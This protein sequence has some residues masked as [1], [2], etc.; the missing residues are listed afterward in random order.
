[1]IGRKREIHELNR[2]YDSSKAEFAAIYGRRRVGKTFLVDSVFGGRYAFRHAGLSP[3]EGEKVTT[4]RDQL[5]HFY[6]SLL[7]YGM[8][9]CEKPKSWLD[10][11]FL[12]EKLL[13][14]KDNGGKQVI[15]I[16]ELPWLDTPRSGFVTALEAFWNSFAC[17]R[18]N[19][20]LIVCGSA[21][22]W[23]RDKLINNHGGLYGRLTCEL[24]LSPFSLA[25]CKAF[26][27]QN[28][29]DY[30]E[31]DVT[32]SYMIIGGIPYYMG[33][34]RAG[35][36]LA[37]NIDEMFFAKNAVLGNEY[38]RLFASVFG[39]PMASKKIVEVL[40]KRN[41]GYTRDEIATAIGM[42]DGGGLSDIINALISSDFVIKYTPFGMSRRNVYYKLVDPFCLFCVHFMCGEYR[43]EHFWQERV[44]S[45]EISSW[46]GRAFEN[47]C[48]NHIS[49]IKNALGISGV[50][51]EESAWTRIKDDTD[52]MQI[53]MIITRRDN[54]VNVCEMKFYSDEFA[55]D[56]DYYK[57][58]L[59]RQEAVRGMVHKKMSVQNTLITTYGLVKN[60]YSGAF[61][62]VITFQDLF[63]S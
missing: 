13:M 25:E 56:L 15:F 37:Q 41:M 63:C 53:D 8:Q 28:N 3:I 14:D 18:M 54:I 45:Q 16:D 55:V 10:A 30:S 27:E 52:G 44:A 61:T 32:Q 34:M 46:R 36:S 62:A 7:L 9:K 60:K 20:L 2:L 39:N 22:S 35:K 42:S 47:V 21:S 57:K 24:K 19:T 17:A 50:A 33:Y 4:L 5:D 31:Y 6:K 38:N 58:L 12:L 51:S 1:M 49:Q 29:I 40:A 23:I 48:F 26:Y 11:F 59:T 43:G